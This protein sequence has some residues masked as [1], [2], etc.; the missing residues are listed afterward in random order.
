MSDAFPFTRHHN[1]YK[2]P[3][4][5][6]L[7]FLLDNG[8]TWS[9][10]ESNGF[11]KNNL[12]SED[13]AQLA[14]V[15]MVISSAV[16]PSPQQRGKIMVP[17]KATTLLPLGLRRHFITCMQVPQ[18]KVT[19]PCCKARKSLCCGLVYATYHFHPWS[20]QARLLTPLFSQ[21]HFHSVKGRRERNM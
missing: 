17:C 5:I 7:H 10:N 2:F 6:P 21:G 3:L 15:F 14:P 8:G 4:L 13:E 9:G 20:L 11:M 19:G 12:S 16:D 1:G 18:D